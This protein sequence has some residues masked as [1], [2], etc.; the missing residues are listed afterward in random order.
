MKRL[1]YPFAGLI[2]VAMIATGL[3]ATKAVNSNPVPQTVE[4]D[5]TSAVDAS[6]RDLALQSE[7][8]VT[9]RCVDIRSSWIQDG[10]VL[11]TL[12]TVTVDEVIKGGQVSTVTV[13]LPGGVDQNRSIPVAM[14]Y[15]GAPTMSPQEEVFLFL[16][17]EDRVPDGYAVSGFAQ[18]KLSVIEDENGQKVVSSDRTKIRGQ[19]GPGATRGNR[20]FVRLSEFKEKVRGYLAQ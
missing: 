5:G 11:V 4:S 18:G 13:A 1:L 12:A 16:T 3:W 20:Q 10:R 2:L 17:A 7:L 6:L 9:G 15:A 14:T 8:I 19:S